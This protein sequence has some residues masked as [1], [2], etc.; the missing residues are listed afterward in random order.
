MMRELAAVEILPAAKGGAAAAVLPNPEARA[1]VHKDGVSLGPRGALA[2]DN[3][4][5]HYMNTI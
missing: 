4:N 1:D 5:S 3:E 2:P